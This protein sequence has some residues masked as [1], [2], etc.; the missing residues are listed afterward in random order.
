MVIQEQIQLKNYDRWIKSAESNLVFVKNS[1]NI[2]NSSNAISCFHAREASEKFLKAFLIFVNTNINFRTHNLQLI[3]R[4]CILS[5]PIFKNIK[6]NLFS[7]KKY[8]EDI[9]YPNE[10]DDN[11]LTIG[12]AKQA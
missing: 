11:E 4:L 2:P 12:D 8:S 10:K 3:Y 9:L 6:D 5:N 7:L 1:I